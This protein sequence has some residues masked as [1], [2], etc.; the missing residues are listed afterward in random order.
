[1]ILV[2]DSG[3]TKCDWILI[4]SQSNQH[5]TNSMG[6]NPFFHDA[7]L[8]YSKLMENELFIEYRNRVSEVYFY[9]AGCSSEARN[10]IIA[11]GL[12][13]VFSSA[14]TVLVDHD[15]KGAALS[16]SQ[17]D[18]GISCILGTGSNSCYF[19][20]TKVIE[21]VPA[22]GYI[23]GDEGSGSYFGKILLSE[24][25]YH[26][27]PAELAEDFAKEYNLTKEGIFEA[28]HHKADPNVYLASFSP[29]ISKHLDHPYFREMV[30]DGLDKFV[31]IH[32]LCYDNYKDVPVHFVGS[33]AYYFKEVLQKVAIKYSFTVGKIEKR[34]VEP[35]TQY[36]INKKN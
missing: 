30:Y 36:H 22:L 5:K 13:R 4:D 11:N 35:L 27:M 17:G 31:N 29:F 14:E 25:L 9:G 15:L 7:D 26:R 24:W 23:L 33:I 28:V 21:K 6:F 19:D 10:R 34:P 8:V 20:G 2:A 18:T 16:T 1:M 12:K 32:V 3:S